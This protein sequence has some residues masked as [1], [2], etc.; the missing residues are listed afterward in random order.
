MCESIPEE[1]ECLFTQSVRVSR[2][3]STWSVSDAGE[4]TLSRGACAKG[5]ESKEMEAR[6][7]FS[8]QVKSTPSSGRSN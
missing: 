7:V 5:G 6:N 2:I 8:F 1:G 4:H 3:W